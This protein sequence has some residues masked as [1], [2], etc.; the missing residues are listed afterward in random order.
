[1]LCHLSI[2]SPHATL[3]IPPHATLCVRGS[4]EQRG[5]IL[6]CS[7]LCYVVGK[8]YAEFLFFLWY[9]IG[10]TLPAKGLLGD[11]GVAHPL[12]LIVEGKHL[13]VMCV[14][15][16]EFLLLSIGGITVQ[17]AKNLTSCAEGKGHYLNSFACFLPDLCGISILYYPEHVQQYFYLAAAALFAEGW[18]PFRNFDGPTRMHG[19]G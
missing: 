8:L 9:S 4:E 11:I 18:A 14:Y 1:M 16:V 17:G 7:W 19:F 5:F 6:L 10:V 3:F 13:Y 2:L 15:V 12:L